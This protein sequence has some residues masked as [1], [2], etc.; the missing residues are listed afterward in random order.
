MTESCRPTPSGGGGGVSPCG[1]GGSAISNVTCCCGTEIYQAATRANGGTA[2][3]LR[4]GRTSAGF[5]GETDTSTGTITIS[6][7]LDQ[8]EATQVAL[9]E[10]QNLASKAEFDRI[11]SDAAAG[12][13]SREEYTRANERVEYNNLRTAQAAEAGCMDRWGC[14]GRTPRHQWVND[15]ANF[16]D[17][18][19]HH[20][21]ES[22][23]NHYRNAWDSRYRAAYERRHPPTP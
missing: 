1:C 14:A 19:D 21:A 13:L 15:S 5:G 12:N 20:L 10:L 9:F 4:I 7:T 17:Y 8:C 18:Y 2:P 11:R 6:D 3:T 23:K 16:D 22:H